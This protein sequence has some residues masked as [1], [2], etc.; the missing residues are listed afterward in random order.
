METQQIADVNPLVSYPK[1]LAILTALADKERRSFQELNAI[2]HVS[3]GNLSGHL[4]KL[5]D[6]GY[7]TAHRHFEGRVP[8]RDYSITARGLNALNEYLETM[9]KVIADTQ[10]ATKK[11]ECSSRIAAVAHSR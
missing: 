8:R 4:R 6:A 11:Q 2:L 9:A 3:P 1:R 10:E 7:V 5:E